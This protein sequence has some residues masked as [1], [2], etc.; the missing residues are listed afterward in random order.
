MLF[1]MVFVILRGSVLWGRPSF[2]FNW[3]V[4]KSDGVRPILGQAPRRW[5]VH[6]SGHRFIQLSIK[7]IT[8]E[9]FES[10][11]GGFHVCIYPDCLYHQEKQH[12]PSLKGSSFQGR[13]AWSNI[14]YDYGIAEG[15]HGRYGRGWTLFIGVSKKSFPLNFRKATAKLSRSSNTLLPYL[16]DRSSVQLPRWFR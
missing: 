2:L 1:L 3:L 14:L 16:L 12:A 11:F 4:K 7:Q 10:D 8:F 5:P 6:Y 15:N 9:S 13:A